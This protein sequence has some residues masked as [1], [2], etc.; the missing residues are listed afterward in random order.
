MQKQQKSKNRKKEKEEEAVEEVMDEED[1]E[2]AVFTEIEKLQDFG[3]NA[4][5]ITK[6]KAA[7]F[8][9]ISSIFMATKK[10]LTNIKG[11]NEA[12]IDKMI[13]AAKKLEDHGFIS[14]NELAQKRKNVIKITT[15]SSVLDELLGGGIE[16]MA[17]TEAFGEFRTGKTQLAHTLCVTTQ[18]PREKGGGN[19]KVI[20]IDTEGTFRP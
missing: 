5:D 6:L 18:L 8:C 15:G 9:T 1:L 14:G 7:G 16:T 17:I 20:Y 4:A 12:K 13:E 3:I 2:K 10:E 19:G 11:I